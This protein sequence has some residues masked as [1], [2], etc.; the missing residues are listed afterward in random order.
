MKNQK[1]NTTVNSTAAQNASVQMSAFDLNDPKKLIASPSGLFIAPQGEERVGDVSN[2][3]FTNGAIVTD[4]GDVYIYYAS[5]DTRL[6][7]ASTTLEKLMD[8]TFNTPSDALRSAD[9][10]KQ[11]CELIAKNLGLEKDI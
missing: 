11:R 4:D 3:A 2:V 9:C 8:Y 7:V 5:S 6:H 10:V 1:N